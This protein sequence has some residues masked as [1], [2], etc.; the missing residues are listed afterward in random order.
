MRIIQ[1]LGQ[2]GFEL[3]TGT[4]IEFAPFFQGIFQKPNSKVVQFQLDDGLTFASIS[5]GVEALSSK[6]SSLFISAS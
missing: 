2:F 3:R 4:A 5:N 6:S 1:S